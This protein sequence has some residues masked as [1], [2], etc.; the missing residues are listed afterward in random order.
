MTG[1]Q[2]REFRIG[3]ICSCFRDLVM[4]RAAV[5]STCCKGARVQLGKPEYKLLQYSKCEV[6]KA[7]INFSVDCLLRNLRILPILEMPKAA[8]L[9]VFLMCC[10]MFSLLSIITPRSRTLSEEITSTP[11]TFKLGRSPEFLNW[12]VMCNISVLDWLSFNLLEE[13]HAI[14]SEIHWLSFCKL[15]LCL[16]GLIVI[17]N[18]V[19]SAYMAYWISGWSEIM[20]HNG[21]VYKMYSKG[22][23][24]DPCGTPHGSRKGLWKR[25]IHNNTLFTIT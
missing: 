4:R 3:V 8:A 24:T 2:W 20:S 17:Y 5:F 13:D 9:Q 16:L 11:A 15:S 21:P 18:W 22:P 23:I 10:Y 19:S 25:V 1:S 7:W 14:M 12:D 6:T